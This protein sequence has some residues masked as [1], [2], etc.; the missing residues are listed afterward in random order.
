[1]SDEKEIARLRSEIEELRRENESLKAS[2]LG[3]NHNNKTVITPPELRTIFS[4]AEDYLTEYFSKVKVNPDE[5]SIRINDERYLLIRSSGLS[6]GFLNKIKELFIDKGEEQ[7]YLIGRNLLFDL[8]HILGLNDAEQIHN[9]MKVKLPI[10]KLSTGPVHFAF[11][12][13]SKVEILPESNPVPNENYM[14]KYRHHHSFEADAWIKKNEKSP[15]PVC[16]MNAGYSSGWCEQSFGIPL[17]AVEVT[18]RAHGDEHCTFI[19]AP[20]SR[21]NEYLDD[22]KSEKQSEIYDVPL[23]F[24]RQKAEEKIKKSLKEKELLLKEVH[25]RVKNNLQIISSI[26]SL[27]T[28]FTD[29]DDGLLDAMVTRIKTMALVHEKFYQSDQLQEV[30]LQDYIDSI[31]QLLKGQYDTSKIKIHAFTNTETTDKIA[32]IDYAIPIGLLC[33]EIITNAIKHAFKDQDF[34]NIYVDFY[35]KG[36]QLNLVF[37]DDGIGFPKSF[38]ENQ[39]FHSLGWELIQA[40]VEQVDGELEVYNNEGAVTSILL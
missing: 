25:H 27:Q 29:D 15:F 12:G 4:K 34:G 32:A 28:K 33:N 2:S 18:C 31:I 5:A 6:Y 40:L 20:P 23:F 22:Y 1:M 8:S 36:D 37:K 16:I 17:T 11:T 7:A 19:M 39:Q 9:K 38:S 26:L 14:I 30:N 24:E 21:I 13:W 3:F 10:D 35:S